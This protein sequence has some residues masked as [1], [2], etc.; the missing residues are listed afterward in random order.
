VNYKG[1]TIYS[2]AIDNWLEELG[3]QKVAASKHY[4]EDA[5][6]ESINNKEIVIKRTTAHGCLINDY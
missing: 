5:I 1:E 6:T 4:L 3:K 2:G